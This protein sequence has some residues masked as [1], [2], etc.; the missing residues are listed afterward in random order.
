[1][2]NIQTNLP[3]AS[4]TNTE[5]NSTLPSG[6]VRNISFSNIRATVAKP[7]P[8]TGSEFISNYNP[9]EMFSCITLNAYDEGFLEN[10]TFDNVH[11]TFPGGGTAEQAAVRDVPKVAGEYYTMGVPPSYALFARNV[12]GL[13]L[14]NVRFEIAAS[15]LRP[16]V[17]F[18]H[19]SDAAVNGLS[20]Q[21]DPGAE[22]ALRFIGTQD[23]LLS[24]ARLLKPSPVFLQVEGASNAGIM[25]DGGDVS[26]AGTPVA[27]KGGALEGA[28]KVRG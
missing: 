18:D 6:I 17:V 16:A 2:S 24:A 21:G 1:M 15:D 25:L 26:K 7:Q 23:V 3:A 20:V 22:S 8:L 19:L 13:T 11:V 4:E 9:G 10:I 28:V 12:R 27:F 14:Q 5:E